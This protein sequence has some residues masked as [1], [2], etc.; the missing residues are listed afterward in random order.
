MAV[1][2]TDCFKK[3]KSALFLFVKNALVAADKFIKFGIWR[4]EGFFK[5]YQRID[6]TFKAYPILI[7][8]FKFIPI[9]GVFGSLAS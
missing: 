7:K 8:L 3:L 5:I 1:Y 9:N 2:A 4:D 6:D